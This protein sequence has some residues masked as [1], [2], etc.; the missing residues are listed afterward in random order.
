[1]L[2]VQQRGAVAWLT[3]NRPKSLNALTE[4]LLSQ[5]AAAVNAAANQQAAR[6]VVLRGSGGNF[7]SGLDLKAAV[8]KDITLSSAEQSLGKF[9]GV[10]EAIVAAPKPFIACIEGAAVGFG[11]DL[12]LACDLRV[13]GKG[14]YLQEKFVDIGLMPDGGATYFLPRLV[15]L[16]RALELL[17]LGRRIDAPTAHEYGLATRV[18]EGNDAAE[19]CQQLGEAL[20]HKAPLA[21]AAIKQATRTGVQSPLEDALQREK[22][23]QARLLMTSDF[24]EG[25]LAWSEGRDPAFRGR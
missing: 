22:Q 5:L 3:L 17:L 15:G 23:G 8:P 13:F 19:T 18:A 2:D 1:M 4:E 6:A 20:S 11:A 10:I 9:Q 21:L 12:A 25:V 16:G 14:A 7:C 24:K